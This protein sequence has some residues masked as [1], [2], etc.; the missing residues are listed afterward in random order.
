VLA[1]PAAS[2]Q[3]RGMTRWRSITSSE[4]PAFGR[5]DTAQFWWGG[6]NGILD[7]LELLYSL[8]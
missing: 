2:N 4:Q 1:P 7:C 3:H 6:A 5:F 8:S